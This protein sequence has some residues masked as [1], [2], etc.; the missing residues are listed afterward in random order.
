[1]FGLHPRKTEILDKQFLMN[2][3]VSE[4]SG[5]FFFLLAGSSKFYNC[6]YFNS[7]FLLLIQVTLL[8][9]PVCF[10]LASLSILS[11]CC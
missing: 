6:F 5:D 2:T 1:M 10:V 8:D 4:L 11:C 7:F 9:V 3:V